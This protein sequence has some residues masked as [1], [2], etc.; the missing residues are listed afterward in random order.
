M[1]NW[2]S[3]TITINSDNEIELKNLYEKLKLWTSKDYM[4][5]G[6]GHSWLGNVVLGAEIG[7]VDTDA[8]TDVRCRGNIVYM[9]Y[10]NSQ[11]VIETETAWAPMLD[12]WRKVIDK[13]LPNAELLYV[14]VE[15]GSEL[16]CSNDSYYNNL[17]YVD[18]FDFEEDVSQY[19]ASPDYVIKLLQK[20]LKSEEAN[21]CI[22][23]SQFQESNYI[24]CINLHEWEYYDGSDW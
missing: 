23:L 1:P 17:Y 21:I 24:E 5:N 3:T 22:L 10:Q 2:C 14:A 16:Y 20:L 19:D 13:Y 4:K 9:D 6:F 7:T 15:P 11:I 18:A 12:L 8:K